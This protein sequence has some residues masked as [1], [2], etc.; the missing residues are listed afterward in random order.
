MPDGVPGPMAAEAGAGHPSVHRGQCGGNPA[1]VGYGSEAAFNRA[2]KRKFDC[3]PAQF[4]RKLRRPS[5]LNRGA[6]TAD[7]IM[8]IR[9]AA[10]QEIDCHIGVRLLCVLCAGAA[11]GGVRKQYRTAQAEGFVSFRLMPPS[12]LPRPFSH[13]PCCLSCLV[14][15]RSRRCEFNSSFSQVGLAGTLR[16]A[17]LQEELLQTV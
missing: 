8:G 6:G 9:W 7:R 10:D 1:A 15:L 16:A 11:D 3:P 2:F 17:T 4:R 12:F 14:R 13:D 5:Y